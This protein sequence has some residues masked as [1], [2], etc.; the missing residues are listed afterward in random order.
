M[1]Q[2]LLNG[3]PGRLELAVQVT[4]NSF[5]KN[6]SSRAGT[7]QTASILR[8]ENHGVPQCPEGGSLQQ[9][10]PKP[11]VKALCTRA[12]CGH[13]LFHTVGSSPL[14]SH[15]LSGYA[16]PMVLNLVC[17]LGL[18]N[19]KFLSRIHGDSDPVLSGWDLGISIF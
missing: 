8:Q 19:Y 15:F 6:V 5:D 2:N 1:W 13:R 3:E 14:C 12:F 18:P 4:K 16:R 9:D 7:L 11:W 17:I 10:F